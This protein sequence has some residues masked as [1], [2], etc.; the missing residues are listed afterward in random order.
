MRVLATA[1]RD[2]E[3]HEK[4][5]IECNPQSIKQTAFIF[6]KIANVFN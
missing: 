5:P 1:R 6:N 2:A 3:S 4:A